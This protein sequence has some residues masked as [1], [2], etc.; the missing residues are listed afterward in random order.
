MILVKCVFG[1]EDDRFVIDAEVVRI[2]EVPVS[3]SGL[4]FKV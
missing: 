3:Q 2:R 4:G 1:A